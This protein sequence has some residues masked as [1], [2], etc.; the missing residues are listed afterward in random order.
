MPRA[1]SLVEKQEFSAANVSGSAA[2]KPESPR[3]ERIQ[4]GLRGLKTPLSASGSG[5]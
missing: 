1:V 3:L 4:G 2:L 5:V